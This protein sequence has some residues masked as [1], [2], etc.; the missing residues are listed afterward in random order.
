[1][2]IVQHDNMIQAISPDAANHTFHK[3]ILPGTSW[4]SEHLFD[5]HAF[6]AILELLPVDSIAIPQKILRYRILRESL[7]GLLTGPLRSR[8]LRNIEVHNPATVMCEYH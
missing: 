8:M 1:M 6:Y 7:N 3:G 5:A 2:T 4:C